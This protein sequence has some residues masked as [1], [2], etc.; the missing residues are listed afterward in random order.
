MD[1]SLDVDWESLQRLQLRYDVNL[2]EPTNDFL[3]AAYGL[4]LAFKDLQEKIS[5]EEKTV[6]AD[7]ELAK[8]L[9]AI[10]E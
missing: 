9:R 5:Q 8:T 4:K 6:L 1:D 10:N 7:Q 2:V 3:S